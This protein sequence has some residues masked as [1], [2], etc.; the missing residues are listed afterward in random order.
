MTPANRA[1][2]ALLLLAAMSAFTAWRG[3][4]RGWFRNRLGDV[5][6]TDRPVLFRTMFILCCAVCAGSIG[7]AFWL[8]TEL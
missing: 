4:R 2:L 1:I 3:Q 6:R 7:L 5:Y 8:A